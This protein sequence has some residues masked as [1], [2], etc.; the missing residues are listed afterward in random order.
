LKKALIFLLCYKKDCSKSK[1]KIH[2]VE[3][4]VDLDLLKKLTEIPAP[5]GHEDQMIS[6]VK[7][8]MLKYA[9]I[10]EVDNIGNVIGT[11]KGTSEKAPRIMISAHM[12]EIG[13]I[14]R[15]IEEE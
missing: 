3:K 11:L 9:D 10:V 15:R 5:S 12:D 7:K 2:E 13:L 4:M 1:V 6:F 14:I 8:Y